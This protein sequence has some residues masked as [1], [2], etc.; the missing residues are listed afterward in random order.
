MSKRSTVSATTRNNWLIDAGLLASA[1]ISTLT[2]IYFLYLPTNGYQ[3]GRNPYYDITVL[4][5]RATWEDLH[6]WGGLTMVA[7]A[8][9]HIIRHWT[10]IKNM[11]IKVVRIITGQ[12]ERLNARSRLNLIVNAVIGLSFTL[13]ALTGIPFIFMGSRSALRGTSQLAVRNTLDLLHTWSGI[14]LVI[15]FLIH[16]AIHWKWVTKV[17][18]KIFSGQPRPQ[19][20]SHSA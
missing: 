11:A 5:Q 14:V 20:V 1:V 2:G 18:T 10:W 7:I 17:T 3:G 19:P 13:T 12:C 15:A 16:F 6:M 8:I 9:F 4:W